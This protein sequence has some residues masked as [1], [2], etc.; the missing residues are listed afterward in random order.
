MFEYG[1][2]ARLNMFNLS[3]IA[4]NNT[5]KKQT[6]KKKIQKQKQTPILSSS[7]EESICQTKSLI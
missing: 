4:G 7:L 5:N 1:L 2:T 6:N 3:S